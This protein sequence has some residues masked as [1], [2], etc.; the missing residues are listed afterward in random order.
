[1]DDYL[2]GQIEWKDDKK[3]RTRF[4]TFKESRNVD[5]EVFFSSFFLFSFFLFCLLGFL[6][7]FFGYRFFAFDSPPISV[8]LFQKDWDSRL[9][10]WSRILKETTEK[11][12]LGEGDFLSFQAENLDEKFVRKGRKPQCLLT[13]IVSFPFLIFS[14]SHF[15]IFSF[16]HFLIFSFSH[17][18]I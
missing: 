14:F 7:G 6:L 12:F 17:F 1:M 13:V 10:F 11:G 2:E 9:S 5:E 3:A 16:S 18:L 4:A 8:F 15:L